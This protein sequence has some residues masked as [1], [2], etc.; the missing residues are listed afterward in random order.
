[1]KYLLFMPSEER[2]VDLVFLIASSGVEQEFYRLLVM[3]LFSAM[4]G[5]WLGACSK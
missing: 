5:S 3:V 4:I 1:V 2:Y